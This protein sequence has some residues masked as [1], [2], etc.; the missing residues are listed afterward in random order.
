MVDLFY[1][2]IGFLLGIGALQIPKLRSK[3]RNQQPHATQTGV[4]EK[5]ATL[6]TQELQE[7]SAQFETI[8]Q[9]ATESIIIIDAHIKISYVN[10]AFARLHGYTPAEVIGKSP[11]FL[12]SPDTKRETYR[13][14][15]EAM[16]NAKPW[17]G[18][19]M[20][21]TKS[22]TAIAL[23][24]LITPV[25]NAARQ[26]TSFIIIG[27]DL[28]REN[29]LG[30]QLQQARKMEAIGTL[31]GGIAHDF[32]NI[33]SAII[34]YTELAILDEEEHI[35]VQESLEQILK[36]AKRAAVLISQILTFSRRKHNER[37]PLFLK[38][39]VAESLK[40]LRST[41]PTSIEIVTSFDDSVPPILGDATEMQQI[42]MNLCTNAAHAM[43]LHGGT[44]T[45]KIFKQ[46]LSAGKQL[47]QAEL[48]DTCVGLSVSDTGH[49]MTKAIKA[50]IFEPY[51]TTK[52]GGDGTGLGLATVHGIVSNYDGAIH[53]K[54]ALGRGSTFTILFPA[55]QNSDMIPEKET[56]HKIHLPQGNKE[57]IMVVDDEEPLTTMIS[58]ALNYLGYDV[59]A[60]TSSPEALKAF[61]NAPDQY[62]CIISD[63]AMPTLT[64]FAFAKRVFA[65]RPDIPFILCTGYS[66]TV[67]E[68]IAKDLGISEFVM[69]PATGQTLAAILH[70]VLQT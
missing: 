70:K 19:L 42:I 24:T 14:I 18:V 5:K 61:T 66:D 35:T 8:V 31:A 63:Q 12:K 43:Q 56:V 7:R 9:N 20:T 55:C 32:N 44:L 47:W 62:D 58:T 60:F 1:I 48:P 26:P 41:L 22:V 64:G 50:R 59:S 39:I 16:A 34:G 52:H 29:Q 65:I 38:Q 27:R 17:H 51:F 25:M 11:L 54:T 53:V 45:V 21:P 3:M 10:P 46:D 4:A 28:T 36:A 69:K 6:S 37:H 30:T 13:E 40:L 15:K 33:L 49:G 68:E 2:L 67:N 23:D 57:K